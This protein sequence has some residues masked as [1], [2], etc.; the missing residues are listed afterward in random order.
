[1][2]EFFLF[3]LNLIIKMEPNLNTI[4]NNDDEPEYKD[5]FNI[6]SNNALDRQNK[7][8]SLRKNK[9]NRKEFAKTEDEQIKEKYELNQN[10]FN[11][12][13]N[14]I[15]NFFNSQEKTAFLYDLI[16]STNFKDMNIGN[17]DINLIK[18]II[19]QCLNYYKSVED[20]ADSIKKFF[21][22]II[23]TNLIDIMNIYK[24]DNNIVYSISNLLEKLTYYSNTIAKSITSNPISLQKIFDCLN[25]SN[26][27][28]SPE[29]LKL[30]YN[31]YEIDEDAV[32][33]NCNI[34]VYVFDNIN[35]FSSEKNIEKNNNITFLNSTYFKMLVSFLDLL[36]NE[37]TEKVYKNFES[38][39]KNNIIFI[40]L[41]LCRDTIDE[42]Y[43][44]NAH[45]GLIKMF[46]IIDEKE[47]DV[48]KFGV[49][50]IASTFLPH[51]ILESN[52][53]DIVASSMKILEQFSYLC[54]INELINKDLINQI[55]QI[56]LA[57]IDMNENRNNP[58]FYY[59]NFTK[60]IIG[61]ILKSISF[62]ILNCLADYE[63]EYIDNDWK[64]YIINETRIIEY[65]T[66]CLK[67]KDIDEE[68]LVSIYSF[69]KDFLNDG[70]QKERFMKL[71]L[72]N[73]LEI[74]LVENLKINIINKKYEVI[75]EI[76]EL[77]L[78]MLKKVDELKINQINFI[79]LYLEK[80]GFKE[81]L[82]TIEGLDFGNA[83]NSELARN[84]KINFFK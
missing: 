27:Q 43:K 32:N 72:S 81:M 77:S 13:N 66:L 56:L 61:D 10:S 50:E 73:F 8:L 17:S 55:E 79:K 34:G 49:C 22:D 52:S 24:N 75:Q 76:L 37:N 71:I 62:I 63:D 57:F 11:P 53:A 3:K 5:P 78:I 1:M 6:K 39:K 82:T 31:C 84:I 38:V 9:R 2:K 47:L 35:K 68:N 67:I 26:D 12:S 45:L 64:D 18:F 41:V 80:K 40:L 33:Q 74:G 70:N 46:D 58:K 83:S 29:I 4:K 7:F 48:K 20:D 42:N 69:Y 15:Q 54:D 36:I 44:L 21:T 65:F 28:V 60:S 30:I 19:V 23:V 51:I 16:S 25:F 59:K 14:V